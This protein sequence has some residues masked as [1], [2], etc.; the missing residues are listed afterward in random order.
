L[1]FPRLLFLRG[2]VLEKLG[3]HQDAVKS[4]RLFLTLS[5]PV[6]MN[7]GEEARAQQVVGN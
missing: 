7:F 4:F 5:G 2:A 3:R 1:A 6:A